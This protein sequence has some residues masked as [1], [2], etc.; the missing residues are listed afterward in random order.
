MTLVSDQILCVMC[1]R[2]EHRL[3]LLFPTSR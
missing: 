2:V 1:S 3:Y